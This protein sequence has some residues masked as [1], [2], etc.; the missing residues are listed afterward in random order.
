MPRETVCCAPL[1]DHETRRHIV[2]L[3]EVYRK[4]L[5]DRLNTSSDVRFTVLFAT[6][7][8]GWVLGKRLTK[9]IKK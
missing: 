2:F 1:N 3:S 7:C 4:A 5:W 8:G 9:A 6:A